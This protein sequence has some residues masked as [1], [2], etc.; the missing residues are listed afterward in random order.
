M[1]PEGRE[2][3]RRSMAQRA[4]AGL[5]VLDERRPLEPEDICR[6]LG[7]YLVARFFKS[8]RTG[9]FDRADH[10]EAVLRR[11]EAWQAFLEDS[12]RG[13][14]LPAL[15]KDSAVLA[16]LAASVGEFLEALSASP[17]VEADSTDK[18]R[19]ALES[20]H[21]ATLPGLLAGLAEAM[22]GLP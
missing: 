11:A 4:V 14:E 20:D 8:Q 17:V 22:R 13:Q 7:G 16:E 12:E 3:D 6:T 19:E 10:G 9:G 21:P 5:E 15:L 2:A 1:S 18:L